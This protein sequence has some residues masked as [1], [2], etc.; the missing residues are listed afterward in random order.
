MTT[1]SQKQNAINTDTIQE[2][3]EKLIEQYCR[4]YNIDLYD[5]NKRSNI[6][7]NEVNNILRYCYNSL[8]KPSH[9]LPNNQKSLLNYNDVE[10]LQKIA[11]IFLNICMMFNKSLGLFSFS[12]FTGID[13]ST[14]TIWMSDEGR[15]S[16]P[17]RFDLLQNIKDYNKGALINNLKDTPVGALAVANNDVETGLEWSKQ[18]AQQI[19]QNQVFILPSERLERLKLGKTDS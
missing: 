3:V 11:D 9:N 10:Q 5:Y 18:Q 13:K 7:H 4:K 8:F 16:N 1:G 12:I 15:L 14:F 19:A 2:Q 6:K 17:Q